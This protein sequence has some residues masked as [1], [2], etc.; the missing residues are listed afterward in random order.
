MDVVVQSVST[1]ISSPSFGT[2]AKFCRACVDGSSAK[3][4]DTCWAVTLSGDGN[5]GCGCNSGGWAGDGIY[6]GG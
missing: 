4:G 5:R 2:S 3:P 1:S 6:M